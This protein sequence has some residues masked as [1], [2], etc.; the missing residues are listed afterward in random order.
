MKYCADGLSRQFYVHDSYYKLFSA[1]F[2]SL[3]LCLEA[4]LT[5][6]VHLES[7]SVS[8]VITSAAILIQ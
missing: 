8:R 5:K 1:I 6:V 7:D 3:T 2:E 4:D